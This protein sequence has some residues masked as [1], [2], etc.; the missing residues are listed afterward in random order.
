MVH[1]VRKRADKSI[2]S[3]RQ[4]DGADAPE[5]SL[6]GGMQLPLSMTGKRKPEQQQGEHVQMA[7]EGPA[8]KRTV[9]SSRQNTRYCVRLHTHDLYAWAYVCVCVCP[10]V[11]VY[12]HVCVCMYIVTWAGK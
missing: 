1:A 10:Y 11:C 3:K 7:E 9:R 5:A 12:M 6:F 2:H 8:P 4:I